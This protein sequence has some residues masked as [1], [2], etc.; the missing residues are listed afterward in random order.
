MADW[1]KF[2]LRNTASN[3]LRTVLRLGTGL[4]LFRLTF[5]N[6]S[7]EAFGFYSLLWSFFGYTILLDFGL[8]FTAQKLVAEANE[9]KE[10]D[11][12]NE[13]LSTVFWS[14]AGVGT[15]LFAFFALLAGP[16]MG[17]VKV[18]EGNLE[19]FQIAYYIFFFAMAFGFPLGLFPEMLR[20]LQRF[21][22]ANW[23]NIVGI[24]LNFG[25]L[26]WALLGGWPFES[27]ITIS[28]LTTVLPNAVCWLLVRSQMP[29]LS[30]HP[31]YFR[32]SSV[33]GVV[34][35]SIIAYLITF[36]NLIMGKADQAVIS[37]TVGVGYV[38]LYQ[39]GFKV[40]EM[41]GLFCR[42]L[43]D[44]LSPAAAA[45]YARND[46]AGLRELL[47]KST[48]MTLLITTPL[49]ALCAVYLVPLVLTLTGLETVT[50]ETWWIG[51]A[52][53]LATYSSLVTNSC[54]KR[55]LM[56]CG[57]E[58]VLLKVSML[59]A[60]LN[61]GL[62]LVL[63]WYLGVLGVALGT[64]FPTILVGWF[65]MTPLTCIFAKLS[66]PTL[67]GRTVF[68]VLIPLTVPLVVLTIVETVM[69]WTE[70]EGFFGCFWRGGITG[71]V[72]LALSYRPL[73]R[74]IREGRNV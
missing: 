68:P 4:V 27:I 16:F 55:I 42:Q 32:F 2:F 9:T 37:F 54:S 73:M 46:E 57:W 11:K 72:W 6:L 25:F 74:F 63:V 70:P 66:F 44:V 38:A 52:L 50:D 28:V 58:K 43:Q 20:G 21:D 17:W 15:A 8:G 64:M 34:S 39:A 12:L 45:L 35:F 19:S 30:L 40:A 67:I 69:P 53:L 61:L 60:I 36:T 5:E 18:S 3:Y 65:W 23:T 14:F 71:A 26:S 48:S 7:E 62:S 13:L 29:Q 56:M 51:Q 59:D 47:V 1:K 22:L 24:L 41:F 49:Y 10:Y 31:R 33:S